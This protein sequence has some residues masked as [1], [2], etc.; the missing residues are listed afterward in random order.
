MKIVTFDSDMI[1]EYRDAN[2]AYLDDEEHHD[3]PWF[4]IVES[5][6]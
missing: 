1:S 3:T 2:A 6:R 5:D 4:K